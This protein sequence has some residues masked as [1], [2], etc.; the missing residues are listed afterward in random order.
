MELR[1]LIEGLGVRAADSAALG[2]RVSDLTDDSRTVLPGSLFVARPGTREDGRRFIRQAVADGAIAVLTDEEGSKLVD[3]RHAVALIAEDVPLAAAQLAERFHGNPTQRLRLV[4][5]TGTNGK[6][7]VAHLIHG[8]MN[9][10]GVRTGLIGTVEIDDGREVAAAEMTTP[11]AIELSRTFATML[12][13]RCEAAVMEASSH[14]LDQRRVAGLAFDIGIF[15]TL[16]TDH[17]DYH[18]TREAYLGA[19]RRLFE[20][21]PK[22]GVAIVNADDPASKAMLEGCRARVV[23]CSMTRGDWTA[24]VTQRRID[25]LRVRIEGPG[26]V[27]E[28]GLPLMGDHNAMNLLEAVAAAHE[29]GVEAEAIAEALT[30]PELPRGRLERVG[31]GTSE[32]AVFVDFAHTPD[33]I[34]RTLTEMRRAMR[35]SHRRGRLWVVFGCGGNKDK[36]K[37]PVMGRLAGELAD[38]IVL[39]SDNPR[40]EVPE[41]IIEQ[42]FGGVS[43][44]RRADVVQLPDRAEAIVFAVSEA[45]PG[46]VVILAGKGHERSQE[47]CD[48]HGH[49]VVREFDD[50]SLALAC[51]R[52][53]K[54]HL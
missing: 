25:G 24:V 42:I 12:D 45:E 34:E 33:A 11:P 39:T 13:A 28:T 27:I 20:M 44:E 37:R 19:K 5:V 3:T 18:P 9:A 1:T 51:L 35:E 41:A 7:T 14:A 47:L 31:D 30:R 8:I 26:G 38:R 2:L 48:A 16:G 17:M 4:G 49:K 10:S 29:L 40:T 36:T 54:E 23:R 15:T 50:A 6:T 21:L 53:R 43:P 46:D 52:G 22:E 32:V